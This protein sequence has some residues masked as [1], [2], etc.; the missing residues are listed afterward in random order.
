MDNSTIETIVREFIEYIYGD[1]Y[2]D[3]SNNGTSLSIAISNTKYDF[4]EKPYSRKQY[5]K[6][7]AEI[8]KILNIKYMVSYDTTRCESDT[9]TFL[10]PS[11]ETVEKSL[12]TLK[13]LIN[14]I[15]S[16]NIKMKGEIISKIKNLINVRLKPLTIP[17]RLKPPKATIRV[18]KKR[19]DYYGEIIVDEMEIN[20]KKYEGYDGNYTIPYEEIAN[21]HLADIP[22][23]LTE[24][25]IGNLESIIP[26]LDKLW[27]GLFVYAAR[28][29]ILLMY[30][31]KRVVPLASGPY[32]IDDHCSL[33]ES[34]ASRLGFIPEEIGDECSCDFSIEIS[35]Y[36]CNAI[37][38]V[39]TLVKAINYCE[40]ELEKTVEKQEK[41]SLRNLSFFIIS[42]GYEYLLKVY[43]R[44][45]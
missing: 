27:G 1:M 9:I 7:L 37:E 34:I 42:S 6:D 10:I 20:G 15:K 39:R 14:T 33:I 5:L 8:A 26:T 16:L 18:L 11:Q 36:L 35:D 44:N 24:I 43:L 2:L 28:N 32:T 30:E 29:R 41:R 12:T 19:I 21:L 45:A 3:I 22:G 17:Q 38:Y 4:Q 13:E 23:A 40:K 31:L 25:Y